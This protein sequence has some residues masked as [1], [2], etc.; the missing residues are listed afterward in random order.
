[1]SISEPIFTWSGATLTVAYHRFVDRDM[2]MRYRGGGVGHK[3][4][5]EVETKHENML[6]DRTHGGSHSRSSCTNNTG[7][8]A[9]GGSERHRAPGQRGRSQEDDRLDRSESDEDDEDY[10]PP[11]TNG[12]HDEDFTDSSSDSDGSGPTSPEA[13]S[14]EPIGSDGGYESYGLADL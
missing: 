3:Y 4:M 5:R 8:S 14:D 6:L 10:M 1:M 9:R 12:S 13:D 7:T 2:F 11:E